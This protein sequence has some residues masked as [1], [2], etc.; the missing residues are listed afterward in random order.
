[1]AGGSQSLAFLVW[2]FQIAT[3]R[4]YLVQV[5]ATRVPGVER[6]LLHFTAGFAKWRYE[7]VVDVM[8]QLIPLRHI[9][10][11]EVREELFA[12]AQ[13]REL[14]QGFFQACQD[15][16]LWIFITACHTFVMEPCEGIRRWGMVC[17]C[18]NHIRDRH[19]G[20]KHIGCNRNSRRLCE[21]YQFIEDR[22]EEFRNNANNLREDQVEGNTSI[23]DSIRQ[24]MRLARTTLDRRFRYLGLIPWLFAKADEV[25][26]ASLC[27]AQVEERPLSDH[28][29]VTQDIVARLGPDIQRR[30]AG[31]ELSPALA[32]EVKI[33]NNSPLDES[34]GEGFHRSTTHEKV[35]APSIDGGDIKAT[36]SSRGCAEAGQA[37]H[38]HAP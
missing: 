23:T 34:C 4:D 1:M 15:A 22:R 38:A 37:V 19:A 35:R 17:N 27:W 10:E 30:A 21:A 24:M 31:G 16:S 12:H 32:L 7:T 20:K 8:A 33:L 25:D 3:W 9:C 2:V 29:P 13:D 28:D 11:H 18:E 26:E 6:L 14:I 36:G 5:L